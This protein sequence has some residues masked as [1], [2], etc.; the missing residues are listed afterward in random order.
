MANEMYKDFDRWNKLKKSL[1]NKI[2]VFCNERELWWCS[3]GAN[4]GTETSGKNELFERPVLILQVYNQHSIRIVPLTSKIKND[5]FH[6]KLEYQGRLGWAILSHS[7][8]ISAKRL[9][10]KLYKINMFQHEWVLSRLEG[11]NRKRIGSGFPEPRSRV[12]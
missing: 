9:Q 10:R 1:E 4:I 6:T 8:T 12:A 11:I 2:P 5:R 3:I 7:K